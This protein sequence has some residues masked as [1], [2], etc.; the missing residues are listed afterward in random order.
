MRT[1]YYIFLNALRFFKYVI[2]TCVWSYLFTCDNRKCKMKTCPLYRSRIMVKFSSYNFDFKSRHISHV[3]KSCNFKT[4]NLRRKVAHN[5]LENH[6]RH[7]KLCS[8]SSSWLGTF[9]MA[10]GWSSHFLQGE[11]FGFCYAGVQYQRRLKSMKTG[12]ST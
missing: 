6:L 12:I 9:W 10:K 5:F 4:L 7:L 3:T 2:I 11:T 1:S 8:N